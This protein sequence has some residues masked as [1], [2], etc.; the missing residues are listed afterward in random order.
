[1]HEVISGIVILCSPV[2]VKLNKVLFISI[3]SCGI[4]KMTPFHENTKT[5]ASATVFVFLFH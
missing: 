4:N 2:L 3:L 5:A 1:M